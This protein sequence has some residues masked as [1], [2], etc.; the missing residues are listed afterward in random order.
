MSEMQI[1]IVEIT[2]GVVWL[3]FEYEGKPIYKQPLAAAIRRYLEPEYKIDQARGDGF[4]AEQAFKKLKI[5]DALKSE[6]K[7]A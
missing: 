2:D 4:N 3:Q 1:N 5:S 7:R 6:L